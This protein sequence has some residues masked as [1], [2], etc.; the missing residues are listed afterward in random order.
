MNETQMNHIGSLARHLRERALEPA[1]TEMEKFED[2]AVSD[3]EYWQDLS[4]LEIVGK[5][6]NEIEYNHLKALR[7]LQDMTDPK[8]LSQLEGKK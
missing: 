5:I 4:V 8:R 2:L 7:I 6:Q 3:Q 1:V